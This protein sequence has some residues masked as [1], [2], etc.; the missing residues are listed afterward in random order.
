MS[1]AFSSS[2]K[3]F[4]GGPRVFILACSNERPRRQVIRTLK[5]INATASGNQPPSANFVRFAKKK[6]LSMMKNTTNTGHTKM[7]LT[8][9]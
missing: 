7:G 1:L 3:S 4:N 8:F 6:A 5:T 2:M 9:Q